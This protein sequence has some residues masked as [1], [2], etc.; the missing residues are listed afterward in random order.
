MTASASFC[1]VPAIEEDEIP[2]EI[3][4]NWK[5]VRLSEISDTNIGLTYHPENVIEHGNNANST[6]SP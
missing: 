2:F 1:D 3:P 6:S 5:W 4:K